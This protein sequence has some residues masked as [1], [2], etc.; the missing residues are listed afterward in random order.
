MT[1]KRE[2]KTTGKLP[3]IPPNDYKGTQA[4]WMTVLMERGWWNG[5]GFHGDIWLTRK[6]YGELLDEC[7]GATNR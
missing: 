3:A 5:N 7:E 4:D 1:S 6:Q 2:S